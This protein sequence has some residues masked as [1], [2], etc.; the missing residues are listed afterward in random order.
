M[1]MSMTID[2]DYHITTYS[3]YLVVV[4]SSGNH[5][6]PDLH[7]TRAQYQMAACSQPAQPV[8]VSRQ[9]SVRHSAS[10]SSGLISDLIISQTSSVICSAAVRAS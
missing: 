5:T 10:E 6:R 4:S 3:M 7:W 1:M 2:Y 9:S 8:L